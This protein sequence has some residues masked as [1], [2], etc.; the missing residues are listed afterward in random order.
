MSENGTLSDRRSLVQRLCPH[1]LALALYAIL[2]V[3]SLD[4]LIFH[5]AT[6]IPAS[7][8]WDY[9][10]F[11]WNLWWVKHA[12][13]NLHRDPMFSN[14]VLYPYTVNLSLH[15]LGLTLGLFTSPLQLML[16]L[17]LIYN[18]LLA[19]SFIAAGYFTFLFLRRH[20]RNSG[21]AMLGGA[22]FAFTLTTIDHAHL[23]QVGLLQTW[24]LPLTLLVWDS[25]I[26]ARATRW[27]IVAA[28]GLG[29]TLYFTWM[30][31]QEIGIWAALL[32]APYAVYTWTVQPGW[33]ARAR[34]LG[35]GLVTGAFVLGP[36]LIEPIPAMLQTRGLVFP[37]ADLY[38]LEF[39]SYQLRWL[40]TRPSG[41][42][43]DNIGQ[44]IPLLT[45]LCLL[46]KGQNRQRWLW[47]G[48]GLGLF[49]LALGP[50]LH[51]TRIPLPYLLLNEL[52]GGQYRTPLRFTTPASLALIVFIASS[53]DYLFERKIAPQWRPWLCGA[54]IIGV[55]VDSGMAA[56]F[57]ISFMPDYRIY[58]EIGQDPAE[59]ALLEVPVG[60]APGFGEFGDSP[61]LQYY[62][63]IHHKQLINGI[64]SR[65]PS[66]WM[67]RYERS[68]LLRG[69]TGEYDFPPLD[70]AA[71]ELADRLER[72]D[73]RYVLVHRDRLEPERARPII[74]FLNVQ[75]NLCPVDEE[76]ALLAYRRINTWA[77]C[78]RPEMSALPE[79]TLAMGESGDERYVGPGWYWPENIGGPQGRWAG[80]IPTSTLR[81]VLPQQA[82]RVTF[83]A[84]GYP[85]DQSV[86]V[87]VNG[88][89]VTQLALSQAPQVYEFDIPAEALPAAGPTLIELVHAKLLSAAQSTDG[90]V[91]DQRPLA[92]AYM[93]FKF[94]QVW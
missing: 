61:D 75:P 33:Q 5:F 18:G 77:E 94:A 1:V 28:A 82:T 34:V 27:R 6:A 81:L 85:P 86:T 68:P 20:I 16:D 63:H 36:A 74:Q 40:V 50:F 87:R 43:G 47:L 23:G 3:V 12:L 70:T 78:P 56:P 32:L 39:F 73:M 69:L 72:W 58:H 65:V 11:Y 66:N 51:G 9:A 59:Y 10:V 57:P 93:W 91:Q 14:Y 44:V 79:G 7:E 49:I 37:R 26:A 83:N 2:T 21:L 89:K 41:R 29:L 53:L 4:N 48:V 90:Q 30:T 64:V 84:W 17:K 71:R 52:L 31:A 62:S 88:R 38:S 8:G 67:S 46:L 55:V 35:L 22:M 76:G 24:W 13:F 92:A 60:P 25:V 54:A 15:S 80:A 45:V 42:L 19:G